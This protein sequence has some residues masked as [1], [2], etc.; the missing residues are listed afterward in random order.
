[1]SLPIIPSSLV[2]ALVLEREREISE[3]HLEM[4]ARTMRPERQP[5]LSR[6]TRRVQLTRGLAPARDVPAAGT[7]ESAACVAC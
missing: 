2:A 4:L 1:M 6:V 7:C 3:H 5:F